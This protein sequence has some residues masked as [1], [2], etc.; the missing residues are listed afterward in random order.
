MS[1]KEIYKL[2]NNKQ[3]KKITIFL[4]ADGVLTNWNKQACKLFK[5]DSSKID[6]YD[7]DS[8]VGRKVLF[9][10]IDNEEI[11]FWSTLEIFDWAKKIIE[12]CNK[13]G[14]LSILTS[15]G[16]WVF[17]AS[18]KMMHFKEHFPDT[19]FIITKD[20]HLCA[21]KNALLID[22]TEKNVN[23]FIEAGGHALLFPKQKD[24]ENNKIN[25]DDFLHEI[26]E[27]VNSM[28]NS[29]ETK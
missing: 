2:S 23:K 13:L 11:G 5:I 12:L 14:N 17:A 22:D 29:E 24:L 27:K 28:L 3:N 10:K 7:F 15:P 1:K 16:E 19:S 18:G 6:H 4:D 25:I 9:E 8:L 21:R 26:E 20:R